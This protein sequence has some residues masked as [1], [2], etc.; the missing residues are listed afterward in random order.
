MNDGKNFT[1][2]FKTGFERFGNNINL[3]VNT[4]LLSTVYFIGVGFTYVVAKLV[5]KP[6]LDVTISKK[7]DTYWSDLRSNDNTIEECYRQF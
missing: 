7:T 1:I 5:N 6:F 2:G 3:I 4:L